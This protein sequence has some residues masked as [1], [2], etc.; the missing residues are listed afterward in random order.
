[1][2]KVILVGDKRLKS[3]LI[4]LEGLT[5]TAGGEIVDIIPLGIKKITPSLFIGE[6]QAE[7]ILQSTEENKANLVIFDVELHP[8]QQRN[9][10]DILGVRVIDRTQLIMDIFAQHAKTLEGEI[11]VELAQLKYL[12]PR[13]TGKGKELS[14]LGGGIGTRGP[15]ERKLEY[16]RR[17][18]EQRIRKLEKKIEKIVLHRKNIGRRRKKRKLPIGAV[19]GYTNAGKTSLVNALTSSNLASGDKLFMT[20]D[21]RMRKLYLPNNQLIII[22]DTVGFIQ[23]LPPQLLAS[24]KATLEE[25]LNSTILLHIIDSSHSEKGNMIAIVR[26]I[27]D[28]IGV[29]DKPIIEIFNKVDLLNK[30]EKKRLKREHP[31]SILVSC[32]TGEGLKELKERIIQELEGLREEVEISLPSDKLSLLSEIYENGEVI[33][34]ARD[35]ERVKIKAKIDKILAEKIRS[36][37]K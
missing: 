1:M 28:E 7:E 21:T 11:E 31:D 19:V 18:I 29:L 35:G 14:R 37:Q 6:G 24:F 15:G 34:Q 12:L 25:T 30:W 10:E 27:L 20:L 36:L 9:L 32:N 26:K 5:R 2:E 23:R 17:R 8:V 16:E 33:S 3:S 4:E 13:L 22:T